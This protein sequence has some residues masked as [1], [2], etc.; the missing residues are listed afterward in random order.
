[1]C[2]VCVCVFVFL[3]VVLLLCVAFVDSL[4]DQSLV[5]WPRRGVCTVFEKCGRVWPCALLLCVYVTVCVCVCV[6]FA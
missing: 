6:R 5:A 1:M 3:C 4:G 2:C